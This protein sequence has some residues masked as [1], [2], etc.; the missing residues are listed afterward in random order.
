MNFYGQK[1]LFVGAHPDD[2]ELGCGALLAQLSGQADILCV[3]LSDNQKNPE[4]KN[5]VEE[6]Y[7]SMAVLGV[8]KD[9]ILLEQFETR[10]FPRDRQA[11]LEYLYALNR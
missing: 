6:H 5:L 8:E 4:L 2:I 7:R 11:I 10:N 1:L 3:T 9:R